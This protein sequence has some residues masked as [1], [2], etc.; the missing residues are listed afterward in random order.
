MKVL[1]Q[2][3]EVPNTWWLDEYVSE[4]AQHIC[5]A[6]IFFPMFPPLAAVKSRILVGMDLGSASK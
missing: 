1:A 6:L 3:W 5:P 4:E 2:A